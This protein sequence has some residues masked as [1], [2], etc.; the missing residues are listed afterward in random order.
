LSV[1]APTSAF[2][3]LRHP[4]FRLFLG[5]QFLS[6][7]GTWMQVVAQ[8]WLVVQLSPSPFLVGVVGMLG[9]LPILLFTLHGGVLADRVARRRALIFLQSLMLIEAVT[10]GT[11]TALKIVTLP[12]VMVLAFALG[13]FTAFEV[14]I[15][16]AFLMEMV[17]RGDV[18]NAIALNSLAFNASRIVGPVVAGVLI[19]S[20]GLAACFFANA[21]S[22]VAVLIALIRMRPAEPAGGPVPPSSRGHLA[23]GIAYLKGAVLPR[24]LLTLSG[25]F[26]IFGFSFITMLPVYARDVLRTGASGYGALMAALGVGAAAGALSMAGVIGERRNPQL[27]RWAGIVFGAS[28]AGLGLAAHLASAAVLLAAAGFGMILN[29]VMTNTLLQTT[30]PDHLR[31][32]VMGFYSLVVLGLAPF[33][34][35]LAGWTAEHLGV[36]VAVGLGGGACVLATVLGTGGLKEWRI[37]GLRD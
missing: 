19:S 29:N 18:M 31:G 24:S 10:L 7:C 21:A 2:S 35:L 32:R 34:N 1:P 11:L 13:T 30:T 23:D 9:S 4:G 5:G 25:S 27:I 6:L 36:G 28:L 12:W 16:Q 14:P 8:G 37:E 3:S 22:Y 17:G 33:G 20:A 26:S 15:R